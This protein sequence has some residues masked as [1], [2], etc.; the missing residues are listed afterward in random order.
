[1]RVIHFA[2]SAAPPTGCHAEPFSGDWGSMDT[3]WT[4]FA[5]GGT[6]E[7]CRDLLCAGPIP[8]P[9]RGASPGIAAMTEPAFPKARCVG[10]EW[11]PASRDWLRPS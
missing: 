9:G 6:C 7:A 4:D 3:D 1:M 8:G 2:P 5:T 10:H 11:P